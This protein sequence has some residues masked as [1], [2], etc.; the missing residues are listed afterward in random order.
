M[1]PL[2]LS[3]A[4]ALAPL[5]VPAQEDDAAFGERVRQ[6]LM[7]NPQVIMEAVALLEQ[8]EAEAQAET[9]TALIAAHSDALF[10]DGVSWVGGNPDGDVT[11][12]EFLD[13]RCGYCRRAHP[14]VA[15]LV[16]SDGDI[17]L[18]VKEFPILGEASVLASRFAI[19][20]LRTA[21]DEAYK[22]VNDALMSMSGEVTEES[23]ETLAGDLDL[24]RDAIRVD[25]SSAEVTRIIAEN[26]ALAQDMGISG[27][28][29]FVFGDRM[30]R[31][32]VPLD[33]MQEIVSEERADG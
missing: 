3:A 11:V 28:P 21:G 25:M 10:D 9:D 14:E 7:E 6:Y 5:A 30:V 27:T 20:T 17:R 2:L 13:Y 33:T 26:R 32:Y 8:R 23:L 15:E 29:S 16:A 12:V 31:G 18:V 4:L 1:K 22:A 19:A 24:D